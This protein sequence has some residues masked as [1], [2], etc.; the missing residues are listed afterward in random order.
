MGETRGEYD[1]YVGGVY[2]LLASSASDKEIANHLVQV[3]TDMLGYRDTDP[4]MLVPVVR[5]LRGLH[6]RPVSASTSAPPNEEPSA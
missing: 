1:A 5:K 2:R 6:V 3:E 4:K